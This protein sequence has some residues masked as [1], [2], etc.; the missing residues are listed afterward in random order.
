MGKVILNLGCGKTYIK[1]AINVDFFETG[2]CDKVLDLSKLPWPWEDN[3]IDEVYLLHFIEHFDSDRVIA[4]FKEIYRILKVNGLLHIQCPHFSGMLALT[5][6]DHKK[7]FGTATFSLLEG[8]NYIF[9]K[10]LFKKELIKI[11]VLTTVP[12]ENKYVDFDFKKTAPNAGEHQIMRKWLWLPMLIIQFLVN[13]SPLLFE[14]FWCHWVGGADEI[15]YRG[16]KI[17]DTK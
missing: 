5:C 8:N 4:I 2:Y 16:R 14:R 12:S 11:N 10:P 7:V 6:L 1:N 9:S 15:I 13:L 17:E 3:S